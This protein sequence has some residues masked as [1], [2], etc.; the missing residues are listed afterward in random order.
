ME[1]FVLQAPVKA[2][3]LRIAG[4]ANEPLVTIGPDGTVTIH[5]LGSAPEAARVFWDA[6]HVHGVSLFNRITE[7]EADL[8]DC[9]KVRDNWCREYTILRDQHNELRDKV[10]RTVGDPDKLIY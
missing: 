8:D 9:R 2:D 5:K 4:E 7:L 3:L 1:T 6:I 10:N